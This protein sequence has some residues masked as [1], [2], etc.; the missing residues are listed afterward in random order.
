MGRSA[1]PIVNVPPFMQGGQQAPLGGQMQPSPLAAALLAASMRAPAEAPSGG[2]GF[3][4][5]P[6][7]QMAQAM[8]GSAGKPSPFF[9]YGL[10]NWAS[11]NLGIGATGG[12][13]LAQQGK[14][15]GY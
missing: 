2:G 5:I 15:G 1:M 4:Q 10:G 8:S 3:G 14:I 7:S 12:A 11:D 6:F 13:Q 9:G